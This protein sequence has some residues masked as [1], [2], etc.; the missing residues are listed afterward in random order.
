MLFEKVKQ[1]H[2]YG[3][4]VVYCVDS[5][6]GKI[7][8]GVNIVAYEPVAAI[9]TGHPDDPSD[10]ESVAGFLKAQNGVSYVLYGGSVTADDIVNYT[11]LPS[12]DGVLVGGASL[13]PKDFISLIQHA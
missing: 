11:Q 12:I 4:Q 10:A 3:L 7:P 1:A 8:E 9:G 6:D 13:T 2:A 5:K